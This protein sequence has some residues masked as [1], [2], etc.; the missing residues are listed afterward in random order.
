MTMLGSI[1]SSL[2]CDLERLAEVQQKKLREKKIMECF[3]NRAVGNTVTAHRTMRMH[4][5]QDQTDVARAW[6][7][8]YHV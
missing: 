1:N 7:S 4:H 3:H 2:L 5:S 6:N 8:A